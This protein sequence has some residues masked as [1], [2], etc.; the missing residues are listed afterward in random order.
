[1]DEVYPN[2]YIGNLHSLKNAHAFEA[3]ISACFQKVTIEHKNHLSL[4]I[5][6]TLDEQIWN[7][8]DICN[9]FIEKHIR[10]GPVLIH[11]KMGISRSATL[12]CAYIIQKTNQTFFDVFNEMKNKR[13]AI[14]PNTNFMKQLEFFSQQHFNSIINLK[15]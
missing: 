14:E 9:T 10:N 7:Y 11:C 4:Q 3:I 8:F 15:E 1:M 13:I 5:K 2:L 12:A 6:D